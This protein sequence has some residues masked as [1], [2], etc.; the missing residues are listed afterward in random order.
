MMIFECLTRN[1]RLLV[2][3]SGSRL[4]FHLAQT[5]AQALV[6]ALFYARPARE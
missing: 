4:C 2:R 1:P 3:V 6:C 5:M